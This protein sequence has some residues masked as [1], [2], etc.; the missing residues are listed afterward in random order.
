MREARI[1]FDIAFPTRPGQIDEAIDQ[2][3]LRAIQ[4]DPQERYQSAA[5]ML[6]AVVDAVTALVFTVKVAVVAPATTVTLVGALAAVLL[7]ESM[8]CAPPPGAG[9]PNVTMPLDE[10]PPVTLVG[11]NANEE[12]ETV[13]GGGEGEDSS[14]IKTEGF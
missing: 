4:P 13:G 12:R 14:K 6:V 2:I 11:F 5:E 7:L 1:G 3:I 10:S 8:T 9:P